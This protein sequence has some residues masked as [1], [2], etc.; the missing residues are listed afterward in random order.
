M[1][2]L[3]EVT[4]KDNASPADMAVRALRLIA[5][6]LELNLLAGRG[7]NADVLKADLTRL[8]TLVEGSATQAEVMEF[9]AQ[10]CADLQHYFRHLSASMESLAS[11]LTVEIRT[12]E[13]ILAELS[14]DHGR[15]VT[16]LETLTNRL[17]AQRG[18][19]DIH[20]LRKHL[21]ECV[22]DLR[23]EVKE[24]RNAHAR[25]GDTV[26]QSLGALRQAGSQ[27][28]VARPALAFAV[29]KLRSAERIVQRF[30]PAAA[31]AMRDYL[32][33]L[34]AQRIPDCNASTLREDALLL[35][36]DKDLD[37]EKLRHNLRR[38]A[39]ERL[40]YAADIGGTEH[41]LPL[42]LDWMAALAETPEQAERLA[43]NFLVRASTS[44]PQ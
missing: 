16:R 5:Q 19:D 44:T 41:I 20:A 6:A 23:E 1:L 42:H 11:E 9:T 37:L 13:E 18:L 28:P 38:M 3:F 34:L 36:S 8:V 40:V 2:R 7:L 31:A 22:R 24:Q 39:A 33:E 43:H 12:L 4:S 10:T 15:N 29:L 32:E 17:A 27:L 30:G 35:T 14:G 21:D 25:F 26:G